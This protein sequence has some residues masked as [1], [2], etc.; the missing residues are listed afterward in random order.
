MIMYDN[1]QS[2]LNIFT[3]LQATNIVAFKQVTVIYNFTKCSLLIYLK[4]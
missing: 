3:L 1:L 4:T 2:I